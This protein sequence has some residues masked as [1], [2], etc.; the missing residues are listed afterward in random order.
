[1]SLTRRGRV[2]AERVLAARQEASEAA[3]EGLNPAELDALT[4]LLERLLERL[5][6]VRLTERQSGTVPKSGWLCRLCDFN[7]CRQRG[8]LPSCEFLPGRNN[9]ILPSAGYTFSRALAAAE[10]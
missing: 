6:A 5:T 1:M 4:Q 7:A 3:L 2:A 9:I 10:S 8:W